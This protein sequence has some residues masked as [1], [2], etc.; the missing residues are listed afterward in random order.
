MRKFFLFMLIAML[1]AVLA[2]CADASVSY[3]LSDENF[4]N[5]AYELQIEPGEENVSSYIYAISEYWKDMGFTAESAEIK[6]SYDLKGT[7]TINCE[8]RNAAAAELSSILT[9]EESFFYDAKFTYTPS[10]FEDNYIFEA[11][12]SLEDI[13]RK[14][15]EH[16][17]PSGEVNA[18]V[19]SAKQGEY[20]L[21]LSLPGQVIKTNA[22]RQEGEVCEWVLKYG[23]IRRIEISTKNVFLENIEHYSKLEETQSRDR[24]LFM[25]YTI[26]AGALLLIIIIA[27]I[28]RRRSRA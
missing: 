2:S 11:T 14:N 27:V 6:G 24:T 26:A 5:V 16:T 28:V 1:L 7:K 13:I 22:D 20:K 15:E 17:I 23:E 25:V 9:D 3:I 10:Y 21:S 19:A 4:V 8:S 18:L 12:V